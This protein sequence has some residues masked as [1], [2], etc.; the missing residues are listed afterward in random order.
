VLVL[1]TAI[2]SAADAANTYYVAQTG[3]S[4]SNNGAI[5]TPFATFSKAISTAVAGDTIYARG[6]TYNLSSTISISKT[7]T[8]ANP[9][10]LLAHPGETPILDFSAQSISDSNRGISLSSSA[11]YWHIKGIAI[12][13]AGDNGF[14]TSGHHGIFE[15]IVTCFNRDSGFQFGSA[16]SYNL[17]LNC[18]SYG[19]Y[20]PENRGENADGFAVKSATIGPGNIFMGNRSFD[21]SDDGCDMFGSRANGVL[22]IDSWSFDNGYDP[23]G[24]GTFN[25]DGNGIKLGHD[26]GSHILANDLAISNPAN[27]IDINGNGYIYDASGNPTVPNGSLVLIYNSTSFK[28]GGRNFMFDENLPHTL[29]NNISL[30]GAVSDTFMPQVVNDHNTWNGSAFAVSATDF[31]SVDLGDAAPQQTAQVLRATRQA[32]GSLPD[33]GSF[34]KLVSGSNLKDAGLPITF[35][36]GGVTYNLPY[37]GAAPDLG[38][39][40]SVVPQLAGDYNGDDVVD[41]ADYT[42]WR[43]TLGSTSDLR[44]NG[45]NTGAGAGVIDQAD[46]TAWLNNFGMTSPGSGAGAG[47]AATCRSRAAC[48]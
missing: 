22:I 5:G 33:L 9:F 29:R 4:D 38:A 36:F 25:G 8:A 13:H 48:S 31:A 17:S 7:G 44:A 24:S 28:N 15:Q 37:N 42:V 11:D 43:D 3:G 45:D 21:N 16:A 27:G 32:D 41:A 19:N 2:T 18:D 39:F 35:T 12:Q 47:S 26:S 23:G 6:G 34:L 10:N 20:D 46:Y 30:L 40:E 14:N 1:L